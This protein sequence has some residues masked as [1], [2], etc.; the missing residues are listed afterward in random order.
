MEA[1]PHEKQRKKNR[2]TARASKGGRARAA[3][4]TPAQRSEQAR[5]AVQ[6][7]WAKRRPQPSLTVT[8]GSACP[9]NRAVV[10]ITMT[11]VYHDSAPRVY[12]ESV[13]RNVYARSYV[14]TQHRIESYTGS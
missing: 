9:F 8:S 13:S 6:A 12:Y 7:R 4:L 3:A 2:M 14:M 10:R 1:P 5:K 11:Y